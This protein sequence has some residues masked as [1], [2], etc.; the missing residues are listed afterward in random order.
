MTKVAIH[1]P[2]YIPWIGYFDKMAKSDIFVFLDTVEYTHGGVINRN[3]I[4]IK[5]GWSW[6][7]VPVKK[8]DTSKPIMSVRFSDDYWWKKHWIAL[9]SSYSKSEYFS[10]YSG[11]FEK[12]YE[13]KKHTQLSEL[14]ID[15]IKY[16]A[17][18][19]DITVKYIKASELQLNPEHHKN[20]LLLDILQQLDATEYIAGTGCKSYME[21]KI[22]TDNSISVTYNEFKPFEYKQR[23]AGFEPYLSAVDLLFNEGPNAAKYFKCERRE[24]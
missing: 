6:L 9:G 22:F 21:D 8:E 12:L 7:T 19:F 20:E 24:I 17:K 5:D 16:L 14:N 10:E 11:Y 23:W 18:S 3:K 15:I 13:S 2:N 1:Q 4:R